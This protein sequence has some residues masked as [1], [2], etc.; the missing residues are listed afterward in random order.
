MQKAAGLDQI[1]PSATDSWP[2]LSPQG[3]HPCW[4]PLQHAA[5]DTLEINFQIS[6]ILTHCNW[7][8]V[9]A[10]YSNFYISEQVLDV[11]DEC[12]SLPFQKMEALQISE[13]LA[14]LHIF[15]FVVCFL[16]KALMHYCFTEMLTGLNTNKDQT[17][18]MHQMRPQRA[19]DM[20]LRHIINL[21]GSILRRGTEI[22]GGYSWL[23]MSSAS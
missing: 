6:W 11:S 17:R 15:S 7:L 20:T 5:R 1:N 14:M 13:H 16:T 9:E 19:S 22:L 3:A 2:A 10:D 21:C 8:W 12:L 4:V 18:A 23:R